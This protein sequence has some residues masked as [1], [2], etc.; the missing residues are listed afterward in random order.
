M[1]SSPLIDFSFSAVSAASITA[2]MKIQ[3]EN[4]EV[5]VAAVPVLVSVIY[6]ALRYIAAGLQL[7]DYNTFAAVR[8]LKKRK[9]FLHTCLTDEHL[10]EEKRQEHKLSYEEVTS[11]IDKFLER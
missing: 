4:H 11:A 1:K 9:A 3:P 10:S 2:I 8:Q 7:S 5:Y 6:I